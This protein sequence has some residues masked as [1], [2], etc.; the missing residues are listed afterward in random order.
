M[1]EEVVPGVVEGLAEWVGPE[2]DAV[3]EEM[4]ERARGESFPTVGPAAGGWLALLA[5]TVG[6]R[7]VFEFG[8]GFGYSAY[9][10]A[11]A[12]GPDGEV[13][14]TEIDADELADAREFFDRGGLTDR[15]H[16]EHGDA[17]ETVESYEGPFDVALIDNEKHRYREALSAIEP[18]LRSGGLV[19]AD[20]AVTAGSVVDREEVLAGVDDDGAN[21]PE[22]SRGIVEYLTHVGGREDCHTGLLPLGEGLAVTRID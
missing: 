15:A 4:D 9:W 7:R 8:S 19:I 13:V 14:L 12:V 2:P 1:S 17:L 20:N 18:K 5:R 22:G 10:F 3:L 6:A 21:L 16:F 11:R